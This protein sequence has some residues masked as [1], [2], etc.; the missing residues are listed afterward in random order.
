MS[1]SDET[2]AAAAAS[3]DA[4]AFGCLVER[5]YDRIFRLAYRVLGNR[6]DAEDV[7]QEVCVAL[8][9]K[10]RGWRGEARFATWLH[11]VTLNAARDALRRQATRA[12]A[13]DGW[14][15]VERLRQEE[16]GE[17]NAALDWL[18]AAMAALRPELRETVALV[19]GEVMTHAEA[20]EVLGLSE[21]TVSWRMSEVRKTLRALA[22][23]EERV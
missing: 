2:L 7:A 4:P 12:R 15:E 1:T 6:A 11:R 17:R 14:G 8:P 5:H 20:A 21:G 3:G 22:E 16:T 18:A 9:A 10:L 13:G 23:K 19:L